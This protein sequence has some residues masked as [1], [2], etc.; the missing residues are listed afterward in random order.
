[1]WLPA[2]A[3]WSV[4][5]RRAGGREV[6][7]FAAALS[8]QA[9]GYTWDVLH[10]T[11]GKDAPRY[12]IAE[13]AYI[14]FYVLMLAALSVVI[15]TRLRGLAKIILLDS[16][17]GALGA[18]AA[19]L[20]VLGP[21]LV[22]VL[23]GPPSLGA[24]ID[25]AYPLMD[26][27]LVAVVVGIAASGRSTSRGWW[28]VGLGLLAYAGGDVAYLLLEMN[29]VDFLDTT[30]VAPWAL[31]NAMVGAWTL[32][33]AHSAGPDVRV[34]ISKSGQAVP[35][36]ATSAGLGVLVLAS[37]RPLMLP[38]VVLASLT[39]A[40][41]V[42]PLVFRQRLEL[43][44]ANSQARTDDLTGI[45]N[46]RALYAA[47]PQQLTAS[48]NQPSAVLLLDLDKF[49]EI[50]DGLGHQAGDDLLRQVA[51]RLSTQLGAG[52]LLARMGGDE[53]V[54]YAG[55][56]GPR[57]AQDMAV[58]IRTALA[59]PYSLGGITV[60]VN[61]SIGIACHPEHGR[62]LDVLLRKADVALYSAKS[63]RSGHALY[64]EDPANAA[65]QPFCSLQTLNDALSNDQLVLHFQPKV[66][67]ETGRVRGVEAL[68]R[69]EHPALGLLQPDAFLKYF[70][71]AG[72][73]PALTNVVLIKALDQAAVWASGPQ[74]LSV[75][76]NVPAS[77]AMDARLPDQVAAMTRA[78]GLSPSML[79]LE[80]TED[81]LVADRSRACT[82]LSA[83]REMGVRVAVD[84][85][86]TGYSSLSYLRELP[87]D[88]I[89]LDRS[90]VS[91]MMDDERATALVASTIHL[92]H[93]VGLEMTAEGVEDERA[94]R[95]LREY[96][97]DLVQ[98]Y[99]I[100]RPV[101]AE[102]LDTWLSNRNPEQS[103][104]GKVTSAGF[105]K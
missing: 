51:A 64:V 82:T 17:V 1:M 5:Y 49:K 55:S 45:P 14:A 80:I 18:A 12:S 83:L 25:A 58:K 31:G 16:L 71:E 89:K 102:V 100:S 35:A 42:V 28:L 68:V 81:V 97:C 62:D 39:L 60:H 67:P 27:M 9:V 103:P 73:M 22:S 36:L 48:G 43:S 8:C 96:G 69:W 33:Q 44:R 34:R 75:A 65:L 86:G 93:S 78:R 32:L 29:A 104:D 95:A 4:V 76:V 101:P 90:F 30:L 7:F 84:D 98:G 3:G 23:Q 59:E 66:E 94:Y 6:V 56:C 15:R 88:E 46:R 50:N 54:M 79:V 52:T 91:A 20:A 63:T 92:A 2:L 57:E 53:F 99:F 19:L 77:S 13:G 85:F 26:L 105:P 47:V 38:A 70:Q 24:A 41:A 61:A 21:K 11:A 87:I 10:M 40:L 72:L 74:H 37:Q